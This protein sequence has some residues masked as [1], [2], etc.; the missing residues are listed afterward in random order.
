MITAGK[1][2]NNKTNKKGHKK[3]HKKGDKKLHNKTYIKKNDKVQHIN[4]PVTVGLVHANWCGHCQHLM[5][6]WDKMENNIKNDPKLNKNCDIVK[7]ES[8]NYNKEIPKYENMINQSIPVEGYPTIF[9]IKNRHIEKYG[10]ERSAEAIGGWVAGAV[11]GHIGGK[12]NIKTKKTVRKS[13]KKCKSCKS[14]NLFKL[15]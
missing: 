5:P 7:I 4:K 9:L 8:E 1:S 3:G 13:S 10:G 14:I 12:P 15:W 2:K 6:E 11:N